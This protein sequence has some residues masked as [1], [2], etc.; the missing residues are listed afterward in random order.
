MGFATD[1]F[2]QEVRFVTAP[3]VFL[4]GSVM[5]RFV[6]ELGFITALVIFFFMGFVMDF[7]VQEAWPGTGASRIPRSWA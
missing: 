1:Y 5:Y 4:M 6:Q 2:A 7:F 3:V